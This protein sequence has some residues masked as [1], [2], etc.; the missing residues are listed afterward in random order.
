[1]EDYKLIIKRGSR[2]GVRIYRAGKQEWVGTFATRREAKAAERDELTRTRPANEQTVS[3][4]VEW[5]KQSCRRPRASTNRHNA[6]MVKPLVLD[7]GG[8]RMSDL[9]AMQAQ[10]WAASHPSSYPVVRALF[11]DAKRAG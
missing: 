9:T 6:Y 2:Y 10:Q 1:M 7:F 3:D 8:T 4:F 11:N 5:W